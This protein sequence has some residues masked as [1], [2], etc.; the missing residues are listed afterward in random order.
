MAK[1]SVHMWDQ[2]IPHDNVRDIMNDSGLAQ[3]GDAIVN[4]CYSLAKSLA[5]GRLTGEK[6]RDSVLARA[7]RATTLYHHIGRRTDAG[8]AGDAYEAL[9]GF[10][11]LKGETTID[12]MV[13]LLT[14]DLL[15]D[16]STSRKR[17]GEIAAVAF[18]RLLETLEERLPS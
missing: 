17:E 4:L 11:W 8:T 15:I 5:T 2:F 13:G 10:L 7:I 18:Q 3:I 12:E 16:T 6:V 14:K 9:V 1:A